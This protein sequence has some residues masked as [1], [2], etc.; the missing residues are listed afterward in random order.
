MLKRTV[1]LIVLG[2]ILHASSILQAIEHLGLR[3]PIVSL[4]ARDRAPVRTGA[5]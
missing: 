3:N 1:P 5:S 4:A 2:S